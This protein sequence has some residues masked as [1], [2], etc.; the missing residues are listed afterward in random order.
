MTMMSAAVLALK[1]SNSMHAAACPLAGAAD[2]AGANG[3]A[4]PDAGGGDDAA[5]EDGPP[6]F[7]PEL[8]VDES[9][10]SLYFSSKARLHVRVKKDGGATEWASR[11]VG[12]LTVRAPKEGAGSGRCYVMF[13]TEGVS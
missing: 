2:G 6:V 10:W 13:S 8:K 11:G 9:V 4:A 5:D 3:A 7:K 1:A 12:M